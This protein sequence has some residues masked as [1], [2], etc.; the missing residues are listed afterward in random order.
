MD[1]KGKLGK[2]LRKLTLSTQ[3]LLGLIGF[4]G[5]LFNVVTAIHDVPFSKDAK[6]C[7]VAVTGESY[8]TENR[9]FNELLKGGWTELAE[10]MVEIERSDN[11]VSSLE[12]KLKA[13]CSEFLELSESYNGQSVYVY[14]HTWFESAPVAWSDRLEPAMYFILI[15]GLLIGLLQGAVFWV[16]WLLR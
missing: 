7:F 11:N 1:T 13:E 12:A 8:K 16:R 6:N 5:A 14:L 9:E 3:I 10:R 15:P 4:S 2:V